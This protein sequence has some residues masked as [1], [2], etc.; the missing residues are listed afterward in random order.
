MVKKYPSELNTRIIRI[1]IGEYAMLSEISRKADISMAE[2]LR[3]ILQGIMPG[4]KISPAQIP[5]VLKELGVKLGTVYE[6]RLQ[7]SIEQL[8]LS[9]K[10]I[11]AGN[12][13]AQLP[14]VKPKGKYQRRSKRERASVVSTDSRKREVESVPP[15]DS[16][17]T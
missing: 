3:Q 1:G 8:E 10:A 6:E 5:M 12:A 9:E 14:L 11:P 2:G 13:D 17:K 4:E 16:R 7:Q 15:P